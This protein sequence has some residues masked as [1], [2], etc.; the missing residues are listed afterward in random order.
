VTEA[1]SG[2]VASV[3]FATLLMLVS[4]CGGSAPDATPLYERPVDAVVEQGDHTLSTPP[5]SA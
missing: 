4:G 5:A 1:R 3:A 2:L